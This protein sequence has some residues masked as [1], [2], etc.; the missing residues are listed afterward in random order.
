[1]AERTPIYDNHIHLS[2]GGRNIDAL[3]EFEAAG[4][5]G[6][7]LVTL[8]YA[9]VRVSNADDLRRSYDITLSMADR[10]RSMTGLRIN[11]AVGP[12]PVLILPLA[13]HLGLERAEAVMTEGMRIA[14]DLVASGRADALGEIGRPHFDVPKEIKEASDRILAY[15]MELAARNC[16]P[17]IVHSE[18]GSPELMRELAGIARS[19]SL[20]PGMV[21]KHFSPPLVRD[22]ETH[23]IFPSIP[24]SRKAV[25]EALSKGDRL[26]LE[27]DYIDDPER[28]GAVMSVNTVPNR[29]RGMLGANEMSSETA[30][31][32]GNDIPKRMF[33]R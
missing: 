1:M 30:W 32:I 29:V 8:P 31:K 26:M 16:C 9:E 2:P 19:S 3:K 6:L 18:S 23:G 17:V 12:Y 27:T 25:R 21:I 10:A 4:G 24:A 33:E 15:G 11:V 28:P 22:D 7:T 13:E 20:D 5:T 14:A